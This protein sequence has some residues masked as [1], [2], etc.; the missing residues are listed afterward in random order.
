MLT[1]TIEVHVKEGYTDLVHSRVERGTI[2]VERVEKEVEDAILD[3]QSAADT[4]M[5]ANRKA[6]RAEEAKAEA[7]RY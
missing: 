1:V 3:A 7:E 6:R 5:R 2:D 4:Q